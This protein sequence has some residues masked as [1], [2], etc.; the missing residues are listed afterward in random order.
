MF[1]I[2]SE[3]ESRLQ[4]FGVQEA[5]L[6]PAFVLMW[7]IY[8]VRFVMASGRGSPL[9]VGWKKQHQVPFDSPE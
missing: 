5:S 7:R 1:K 3:L 6:S 8:D 9:Q 2:D 4:S